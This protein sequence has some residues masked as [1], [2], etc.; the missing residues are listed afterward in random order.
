M[1]RPGGD[2]SVFDTRLGVDVTSNIQAELFGSNIFDTKQLLIV[3]TE[4]PDNREV[5]GRPRTIGMTVRANF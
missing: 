5:L 3:D 4:I 2:F 1:A